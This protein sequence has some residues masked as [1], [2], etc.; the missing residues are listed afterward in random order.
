MG[1]LALSVRWS[2]AA[3]SAASLRHA[4]LALAG[5]E[6]TPWQRYE[7]PDI[8][9]SHAGVGFAH[10]LPDGALVIWIDGR[11]STECRRRLAD[12]LGVQ[13]GS[14]RD[15][16][17]ALIRSGWSMWQQSVADRLDGDFALVIF[18]A[19]RHALWLMRSPGSSR[20][21]YFVAAAQKVV[22]ATRP[23]AALHAAGGALKESHPAVAAYFSLRAPAVGTCYFENVSAV[24]PG[25]LHAFDT[26][27]H[28]IVK[29]AARKESSALHFGDD[30][31]AGDAWRDVL[32]AAVH[33]QLDG[34][35]QP[36]VL[37]SGGMD[38][39]VL[40]S[41][42]ARIRPDLR[43]YSWRLPQMPVSDESTWIDATCKHVGIPAHAFNGDADWPLARLSQW[44]VEDDGPPSNPYR[45]LQQH[46]FVTAARSGCDA[47]M[48]GNFGDH[49]YPPDAL[50]LRSA[51]ADRG[52]GWALA[53]ELRLLRR[54]G[55][56][57]VWRDPGWRASLRG[58][59]KN[60]QV[61]WDAPGWMQPHWREALID[62]LG[63][64]EP[65]TRA[66]SP[67]ALQ[68]AE[69]GRRFHCLFGI[70][71]VAPYRDPRV[72]DF[73][74]ALP[75]HYQYRHG[76]SKWLTREI[77]RGALPETVRSRPKAGSLAAFF[78]KG[79]LDRSAVEVARL[80]DAADARWPQYVAPEA[81]RRA[82]EKALT[83]ADL[84]LI[85]LCLS[86]E[87]WWRAHWGAGPAVLAS[88]V[89]R[90]DFFEAFRD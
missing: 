41:L 20:G 81:L 8:V 29:P 11:L 22:V 21:L 52:L 57:A 3:N 53:E 17:A 25:E 89:N 34:W 80:L 79:V 44:P 83:E 69:L 59:T 82:R 9:A 18:D 74:A 19:S 38:S 68:D 66:D 2:D 10:C 48:S 84:L 31:E 40:A 67:E 26:S 23:T 45:W 4:E 64:A 78:R 42:G 86:Y 54:L 55:P 27:G 46:A 43:A 47:L 90:G 15:N 28:R 61:T 30:V 58:A 39:S 72:I 63:S 36:G 6:I 35:R 60:R 85:W 88:R 76:Q 56:R 75:A 16:D 51:V 87:L 33:D 50:W 1:A 70:E 65:D 62:L 71:L 14:A 49:L 24:S 37:L 5:F 32:T 7:T 73:A 77:M 12:A 13:S